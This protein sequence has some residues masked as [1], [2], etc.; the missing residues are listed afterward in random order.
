MKIKSKIWLIGIVTLAFTACESLDV[1]N[2]NN[3]DQ[4]ATLSVGTDLLAAMA[5]GYLTYWQGLHDD[6]PGMAIG[7]TADHFGV[8]WGNFAGRRMGE[9]PR[10][11]YN[12]RATE[13]PDYQQLV[14]D[15]WFGSL[16]AVS[17]ANDIIV[18]LNKGVTIDNGGPRDESIL[19]S[20]RMLRGLGWGHL[21]LMFDRA[22]IAFE[23]T[24]VEQQIP[25]TSYK[26]M[27][28][29]AVAELEAAI[30]IAAKIDAASFE[31]PHFNGLNLTREQ[32]IQLAH[33]YAARFL[34]NWPRT[35][36]ENDQVN[37][38]AVYDHASQGLE[39]DFGPIADGN[40]W[41][42][43]QKNVFANANNGAF[44]ARLDQRL[45][46]A[47][48][49]SQPTR[50][51][52]V[53]GRGEAPLQDSMATSAD[54]RLES[55]FIFVPTNNFA[56]DRGEWHFS[57]YKH[58]RNITDPTFAGDATSSGPIPTFLAADND[59]LAAEALLQ[60]NR[61]GEAIDLINAGTRVTRGGL[62]PLD[63]NASDAEVAR[64]IMYERAIEL[65]ST[66]PLGMWCY[67]RRAGDRQQFDQVD[68]LGG[69]QIGTPAHLPVPAKELGIREEAPYNFGGDQ[70]P[71]GIKP[72]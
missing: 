36:S 23:D 32:F 11:S 52:E 54:A 58:N 3:P 70:D 57:H 63:A 61:K 40:L 17:T 51:P 16:S 46:A 2:F 66:D 44:W 68:D 24:D 10:K 14:E 21:G 38:Q 8:S 6:H 22:I 28:P 42:G 33:S 49:P 65:M 48:D 30:E 72:F 67:R 50:Y 19:A 27:I 12:N 56:V 60:L 55:D 59:L 13:D 4:A 9:E 20:A 18:A 15:P 43:Y 25:Y 53:V 71:E 69:L 37:W 31:H 41:D 62:A 45:V 26:D 1:D 64:A 34:A 39:F 5:G 29:P 47:L 35:A 7:I